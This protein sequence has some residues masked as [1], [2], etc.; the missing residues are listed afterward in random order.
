MSKIHYD[1]RVKA[2]INFEWDLIDVPPT[3]MRF[4]RFSVLLWAGCDDEGWCVFKKDP[5]HNE[6][7]RIDFL[8]PKI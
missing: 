8:P 6:I 4:M 7:L 2:K 5:L 1:Y 3:D